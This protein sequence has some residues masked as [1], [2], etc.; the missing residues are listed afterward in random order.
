MSDKTPIRD[1]IETSKPPSDMF[2]A[3]VRGS[4]QEGVEAGVFVSKSLGSKRSVD[5][6]AGVSSRKGWGFRAFYKR[7]FGK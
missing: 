1:F 2:G 3:G 7:V 6:E 4:Q 5:A